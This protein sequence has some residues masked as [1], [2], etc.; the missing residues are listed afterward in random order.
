MPNNGSQNKIL[1]WTP[2]VL[3][4]LFAIF[5]STFA[6]DAIDAKYGFPEIIL[7]ASMHSIPTVLVALAGLVAWR[8]ERNGGIVFIA[9]GF[10]YSVMAWGTKPFIA[11]IFISG[12]LFLIGILFLLNKFLPRQKPETQSS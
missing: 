3:L 8:K 9:L 6:I 2:R 5:I 1:Y 11:H 4:V 12:P 7:A 10:L